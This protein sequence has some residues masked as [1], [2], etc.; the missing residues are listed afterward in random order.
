MKL[1]QNLKKHLPSPQEI[2]E[3]RYLHIFGDTLKQ[4]ELWT[5]NRSST[6]R[7]IAIGIFCAFLPMPFEMVVAAFMAATMRG[8]LPFA[9]TVV[10]ISNPLTWIPMYTPPYLIGAKILSLEPVEI[11]K[12]TI[13]ELGWHYVALW[14][15]CLMVG[16]TLGLLSHFLISFTW[17]SQVRQRWKDRKVRRALKQS[18]RC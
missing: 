3:Y 4:A 9:V 14:L 11:A 8:N 17:R 18:K 7:G 13:F 5:F 2:A 1:L 10:W 6:A 16:V 15:G 12:I